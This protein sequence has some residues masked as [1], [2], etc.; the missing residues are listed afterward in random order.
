MVKLKFVDV[1][2]QMHILKC[3]CVCRYICIK[4]GATVVHSGVLFDIGCVFTV[5]IVYCVQYRLQNIPHCRKKM[6]SLPRR[7]QRCLRYTLYYR[8][9]QHHYKKTRQN[10]WS[11]PGDQREYQ[12]VE[13]SLVSA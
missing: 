1:F 6:P 3:V 13:E 11:S 2:A 5:Y 7:L 4:M 12:S 10:D 9:V 8:V